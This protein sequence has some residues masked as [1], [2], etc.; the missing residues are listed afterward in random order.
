[1]SVNLVVQAAEITST[2]LKALYALSGADGI[3]RIEKVPHQAFRL[4]AA[5]P[6]T[7]AAV[8]AYC[9][10]AKLDFAFV[11]AESRLADF[12]LIA[13]DMDSTLI[14]IECVD[15]IADFAGRKP[16]VAAI[17]AS[18]MRGEIDWPE[19]LR[20]RVALLAGLKAAVLQRVFDER[21]RLS[22]GATGLLSA[23]R[24]TGIKVLLVSGGFTFFTDR[25]KAQL[26]LDFAYSNDLEINDGKLTGRVTGVLCDADAKAR[27]LR[28]TAAMLGL[29]RESCLAIGDGANDLKMMA[30]AGVSVAYRAKTVVQAQASLAL[31]HVGLDGVLAL[32]A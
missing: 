22:P 7:R 10:S 23:A 13:M 11:A 27:H 17:T 12:G 29:R 21:L 19:S 5:N 30:E 2:D 25:L 32:F 16:Q 14:T 18:A 26:S 24:K 4:M 3:A 6:E 31:N 20:R 8:H 9:E 15:E 1:M 28:E